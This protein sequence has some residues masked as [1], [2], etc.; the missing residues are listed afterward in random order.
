MLFGFVLHNHKGAMIM[1]NKTRRGHIIQLAATIFLAALSCSTAQ[2][3]KNKSLHKVHFSK[4]NGLMGKW[5]SASISDLENYHF[6]TKFLERD[7][8]EYGSGI[9]NNDDRGDTA[10][11]SEIRDRLSKFL[12]E[13]LRN[14]R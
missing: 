7:R 12:T 9:Y 13:K 5:V 10:G 14:K 1:N 2:S 11:S 4:G 3:M 8:E 6:F